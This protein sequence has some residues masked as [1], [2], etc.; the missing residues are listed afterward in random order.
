MCRHP[1]IPRAAFHHACVLLAHTQFHTSK[2]P[3]PVLLTC[4]SAMELVRW[5]EEVAAEKD[6]LLE[7]VSVSALHEHMRYNNPKRWWFS[8]SRP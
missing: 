5:G 8:L 6:K 2:P 7:S 1:L 4:R 3:H